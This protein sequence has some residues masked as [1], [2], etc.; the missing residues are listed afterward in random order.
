MFWTASALLELNRSQGWMWAVQDMA[1]EHGSVQH[2]ALGQGH[3]AVKGGNLLIKPVTT[4][5]L[6]PSSVQGTG[7]VKSHP[8]VYIFFFP[9][10]MMSISL[11][12]IIGFNAETWSLR[13]KETSL[14]R[15]GAKVKI[16]FCWSP[17]RLWMFCVWY[18]CTVLCLI[19]MFPFGIYI[20]HMYRATST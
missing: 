10:H 13:G 3:Q 12:Y 1:G 7:K 14:F 2:P 6:S 18:V 15:V 8:I 5:I 11:I 9:Q 20:N 19:L 4:V 16:M 17:L